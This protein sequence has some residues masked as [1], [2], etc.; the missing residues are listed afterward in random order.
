MAADA[1]LCYSVARANVSCA[2][3]SL[4]VVSAAAH[5][6]VQTSAAQTSLARGPRLAYGHNVSC[7]QSLA[8]AVAC[9][10]ARIQSRIAPMTSSFSGPRSSSW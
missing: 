2:C 4:A 10:C 3:Q 9:A 8:A 1:G 7:A 6:L 5:V